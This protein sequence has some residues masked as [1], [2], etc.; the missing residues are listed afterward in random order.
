MTLKTADSDVDRFIKESCKSYKE[1]NV[2]NTARRNS[3]IKRT[4][5]IESERRIASAKLSR[6]ERQL[7]EQLKQMNIEK[8]KNHIVHNLRDN[9][10]KK[11][12]KK[13]P[14]DHV[15]PIEP[16]PVTFRTHTPSPT[17]FEHEGRKFVTS[18]RRRESKEFEDLSLDTGSGSLSHNH[19]HEDAGM[20]RRVYSMSYAQKILAGRN[21]SNHSSPRTS[22]DLRRKLLSK[23]G[24]GGH[25]SDSSKESLH[26]STDRLS[27]LEDLHWI[28]D[29]EAI[30]SVR[31]PRKTVD[32]QEREAEIHK[33][34]K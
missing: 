13:I 28:G 19:Y 18:R 12:V 4:L 2:K 20:R 26:D 10:T 11:K 5:G 15:L 34:I 23:H 31:R 1:C 22:P 32:E 27:S 3:L 7:R 14:E 29:P 6:E 25:S 9:K 21:S 33:L 24:K 30:H 8:A 17:E 16:Y